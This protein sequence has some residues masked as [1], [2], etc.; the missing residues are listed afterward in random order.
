MPIDTGTVSVGCSPAVAVTPSPPSVMDPKDEISPQRKQI[1]NLGLVLIIVGFLFFFS[2]FIFIALGMAD[3]A[4]S[5]PPVGVFLA[6]MIGMFMMVAG[7]ALRTLG[8][9]GAAG[10]G[11]ILD[12]REAGEDLKPWS[13]MG[14]SLIKEAFDAASISPLQN[15]PPESPLPFDEQLRRLHRLHE[16]GLITKEEYEA[17]KK[18][19]LSRM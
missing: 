19:I 15:T 14:G 12:P 8:A 5:F 7:K 1:Y 3:I 11:L 13:R 2:F 6:P 17:K 18:E 16:E 10:S 4:I 9:R